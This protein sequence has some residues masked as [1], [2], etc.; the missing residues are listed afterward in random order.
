M[1]ATS[2]DGFMF[3]AKCAEWE[4]HVEGTIRWAKANDRTKWAAN[5][6]LS[7]NNTAL[8]KLVDEIARHIEAFVRPARLHTSYVSYAEARLKAFL[9]AEIAEMR[10]EA[11]IAL[12]LPL[13][14]KSLAV[15]GDVAEFGCYRG[16]LSMKL[17]ALLKAWGVDKH[18]YAFDTFHG[19]EIEDP[20]GP[21]KEGALHLNVGSYA[22]NDDAYNKLLGWSAT[23][24]L[25]PIRGDATKTCA[26]LT[27][28]LSF[29]WLDLDMDVLM[30]PVLHRIWHL[31]GPDTI[32]GIDDDGR[33]QTPTV[34]PWVDALVS[35]GAVETILN[36]D[37]V[38]PDLFM[39]F[40]RKK[41][42][43][44]PPVV[45]AWRQARPPVAS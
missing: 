43:L 10:Q 25:T 40:V 26:Q 27:K 30:E 42:P 35:S 32:I 28:P 17:A 14:E 5:G 8:A 11:N 13:F 37:D 23:L 9:P 33:P 45:G 19:F 20:A 2:P 3:V 18:C 36:S 21:G 39:R 24:P 34:R 22:D 31:C 41:G 16:V 12:I 44:P 38:A 1:G 4:T 15:P 7:G 6:V 29:V